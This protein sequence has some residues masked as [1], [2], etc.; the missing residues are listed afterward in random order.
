M[1]VASGSGNSICIVFIS[2]QYARN[3][4]L[5]TLVIHTMW[6]KRHNVT[7]ATRRCCLDYLSEICQFVAMPSSTARELGEL[8]RAEMG[9]R[10]VNMSELSRR[11]EIARSTLYHQ[12]N[13]GTLTAPALLRVADALGVTVAELIGEKASA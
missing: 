13:E 12:I 2:G 4:D 11:T 8:I 6:I 9:R 7:C 10:R 3:I 1:A 5:S